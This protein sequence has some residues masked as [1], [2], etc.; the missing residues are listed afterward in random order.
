V[1]QIMAKLTPVLRGWGN[2][3]RTGNADRE[4]NKMDDL[5]CGACDAGS[6]GGVGNGQQNGLHSAALRSTE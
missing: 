6:I 1:K 5:W 4:F 3:F 2:Y